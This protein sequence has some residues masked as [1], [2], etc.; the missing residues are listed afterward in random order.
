MTMYTWLKTALSGQA[1]A[2]PSPLLIHLA[3]EFAPRVAALWRAP[4]AAFLTATADRR[5][6][7]CLALARSDGQTLTSSKADTLLELALSKAI[8][9]VS[10]QAPQGLKRAL[11]HMGER[12]WSAADYQALWRTLG[13]DTLAKPLRHATTITPDLVHALATLPEPLAKAGVGDFGLSGVQARLLAETFALIAQRQGPDA[14]QAAAMR[15]S[16]AKS[17]KRLFEMVNEDVLPEPPAPP[18]PGTERIRP[19]ATKAE[20]RGAAGRFGNCLRGEIGRA[21]SG[22]TAFYEWLGPPGAVVEIWRD[23]LFGWRL[24]EAKLARN[25]A[26]PVTARDAIVAE[27]KR[28]GVHVG[29]TYWQVQN[30][31]NAAHTPG[32]VPDTNAADVAYFFE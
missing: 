19:L 4:H 5:H 23:P 24:S 13:Q 7:V 10:P 12:A 28:M 30:A 18:F 25:D 1:V 21:A 14:A 15:W 9:T 2:E 26:V 20:I 17:A 29:Q 22:D 31:L 11:A 32:Y 3:G 16:G 27:L 6:L 8:A